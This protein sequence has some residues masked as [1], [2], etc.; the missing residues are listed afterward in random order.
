MHHGEHAQDAAYLQ[1]TSVQDVSQPVPPRDIK[2]SVR[3]ILI[4]TCS[5]IL[6]LRMYQQTR[7]INRRTSVFS[8]ACI[9]ALCRLLLFRVSGLVVPAWL[10][11]QLEHSAKQ[12]IATWKQVWTLCG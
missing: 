10:L 1:S 3:A 6:I 7:R 9:T 12:D 4:G 5:T 2:S 8:D 11:A